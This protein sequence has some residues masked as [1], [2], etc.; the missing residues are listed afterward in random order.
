MEEDRI[1]VSFQTTFKDE[2]G[3]RFL[4]SRSGTTNRRPIGAI[5]A[6]TLQRLQPAEKLIQITLTTR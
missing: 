6:S 4:R 3:K 5:L 2:A 1:H